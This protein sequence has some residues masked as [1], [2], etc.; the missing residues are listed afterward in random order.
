[1][2]ICHRQAQGNQS[3]DDAPEGRF[4]LVSPVVVDG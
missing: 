2:V 1:M 3:P 4:G